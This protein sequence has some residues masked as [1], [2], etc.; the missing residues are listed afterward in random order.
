MQKCK[1][2]QLVY[3]YTSTFIHRKYV[4]VYT[5]YYSET[6]KQKFYI[7]IYIETFYKKINYNLI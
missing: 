2:K 3:T 4:I 7:W 6:P 1:N 5:N